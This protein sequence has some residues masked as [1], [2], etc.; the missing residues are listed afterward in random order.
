MSTGHSSYVHEIPKV[1]FVTMLMLE[2]DAL[3]PQKYSLM[4]LEWCN[5]EQHFSSV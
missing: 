2:N 5:R 3:P 1:T 4:E